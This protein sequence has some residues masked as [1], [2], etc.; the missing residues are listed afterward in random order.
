M[1][2]AL[3]IRQ[4]AIFQWKQRGYVPAGRVLAIEEVT[5]GLVNRHRLRPDIF[6]LETEKAGETNH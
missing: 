3:G 5:E 6:G 2:R 1:A 4:Q